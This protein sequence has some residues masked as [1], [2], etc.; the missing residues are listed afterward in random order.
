MPIVLRGI[1]GI[2]E[3]VGIDCVLQLGYVPWV[4][5]RVGIHIYLLAD[6]TQESLR[7]FLFKRRNRGV[8]DHGPQ[9][10][11]GC[12]K[13]ALIDKRLGV[14]SPDLAAH[15]ARLE[16]RVAGASHLDEAALALQP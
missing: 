7:F 16:E 3:P 5:G 11:F 6:S 14:A 4:F 10:A 2:V 12:M 15:E 8:S 9:N 1:Q 13:N